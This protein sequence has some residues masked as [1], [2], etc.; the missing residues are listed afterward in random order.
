[1]PYLPWGTGKVINDDTDGSASD[2]T[3]Q[4][5]V[6]TGTRAPQ[7]TPAGGNTPRNSSPGQTIDTE[8]CAYGFVST[9]AG[10]DDMNEIHERVE[11]ELVGG[12]RVTLVGAKARKARLD[13]GP[14]LNRLAVQVIYFGETNEVKEIRDW[15]GVIPEE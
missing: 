15:N 13:A 4:L 11:I 7:S 10:N 6:P 3:L 9:W 2:S 5:P 14:F 12:A 8:S 1:M